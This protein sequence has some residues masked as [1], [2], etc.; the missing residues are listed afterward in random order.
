MAVGFIG[1]VFQWVSGKVGAEA[2]LFSVGANRLRP[3]TSSHTSWAHIL[4]ADSAYVMLNFVVNPML[5]MLGGGGNKGLTRWYRPEALSTH[6]PELS[7][8]SS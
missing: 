7:P 8:R 3:S 2:G 1:L 6:S 5:N 4:S